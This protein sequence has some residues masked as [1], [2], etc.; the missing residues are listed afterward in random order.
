MI[1]KWLAVCR[2]TLGDYIQ[3]LRDGGTS[4]DLELWL[5]SWAMQCPVNV[6]LRDAAWSTS[7]EGLDF[8][9]PSIMLTS[10][11]DGFWCGGA[12]EDP[13]PVVLSSEPSA[14]L[15]VQKGGHPCVAKEEHSASGS[16]A[17]ETDPDDFLEVDAVVCTPDM[18]TGIPRLH[19]CLVCSEQL[20]SGLALEQH[21]CSLHPLSKCFTCEFCEASFNTA[22]QTSSHV[23]NVHCPHKVA[24]KEYDYWMV[25]KAKMWLHVR[26]HTKGLGCSKCKKHFPSLP[27]LLAHEHLHKSQEELECDHCD[28]V[29]KTQTA[30][31]IHVVGKHGDG[32]CCSKC[33]KR[34]D[35]PVQKA[36]HEHKCC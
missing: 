2:L 18:P 27:V 4:D 11:S 30:L 12:S 1:E 22:C 23:A 19:L 20:H 13:S 29:Y 9:N 15:T 36:C 6:F 32:Y 35:T 33:Q 3:H 17:E 24:C 7:L 5:S 21:L 34:F 28:K 26:I 14:E 8:S 10:Y 16:T 25:S 31:H